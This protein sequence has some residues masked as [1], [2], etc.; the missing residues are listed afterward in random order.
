MV[1]PFIQDIIRIKVFLLNISVLFLWAKL[2]QEE[3]G[4]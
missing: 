1:L 3:T 4:L 2:P